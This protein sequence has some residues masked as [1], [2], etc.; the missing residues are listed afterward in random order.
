VPTA[1]AS[2]SD[3]QPA[4]GLIAHAA[5]ACR[6]SGVCCSSD[7]EIPVEDALHARLGRAIDAGDLRPHGA[8][9]LVDRPEL[10]AG[11]RS[12]LGRVAG[13]CVFH[14]AGPRGCGLH[15]WGG[16]EAKPIACRQFPWVAVHDPRGTFASLSHVC[17]SA[18]DRLDDPALLILAPLPRAAL[19]FDGLDVR[20]SL[21][22]S[23]S[24]RRLLDWDALSE[25]ETQALDACARRD[26]PDDVLGDLIALRAHARRWTP[27]QGR[28]AGWIASWT[29]AAAPPLSAPWQPDLALDAIVRAAVPAGLAVPSPIAGVDAPPWSVSAPLIRR[30]V[31]A[32]L[33]ACWPLHYGTGLATALAYVAALLS[34][35]AVEIARRQPSTIVAGDDVV[36]AALAE[37][38][39]LVVHLAA[40]DAL[41]RGLDAWAARHLDGGL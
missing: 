35:V 21:P 26:A 30:Y 4:R 12:V 16:A 11:T 38:D 15:A 24:A 10:P 25:W 5:Y 14:T 29:P 2:R 39:R 6:H 36:R 18:R 7:W 13:R 28:L 3:A 8:V 40:P 9:G 19:T 33:V 37:T 41:A 34:V 27:A 17:P 31:A 23:L 1:D 32:R 22:P 20:R